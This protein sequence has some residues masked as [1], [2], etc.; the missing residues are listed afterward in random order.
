MQSKLT[1]CTFKAIL[2]NST[3]F[4]INDVY[5]ISRYLVGLEIRYT[6]LNCI[7]SVGLGWNWWIWSW[8]IWQN[9]TSWRY[10]KKNYFLHSVS[11]IQI[12][13]WQFDFLFPRCLYLPWHVPLIRTSPWFSLQSHLKL[14]GRLKHFSPA[15]VWQDVGCSIHSLISKNVKT[16]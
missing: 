1:Y 16:I 15:P 7:I 4:V 13:N 6:E 2:Y 9:L 11:Y 8:F 14:P 5:I 3:F 10:C 12:Y